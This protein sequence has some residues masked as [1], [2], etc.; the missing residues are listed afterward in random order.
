[1]LAGCEVAF[2]FPEVGE[3]SETRRRRLVRMLGGLAAVALIAVMVLWAFYGSRYS[4]RPAGVVLSPPLADYVAP[5]RARVAKGILLLAKTRILPESY[6][7]G[8]SDVRAMANGMPS[9][10]MGKVYLHGVWFYFPSVLAIKS[11]IGFL[12]L[13]LAAGA[14]CVA[15]KMKRWREV[16]FVLVP[17]GV[18]LW[19]AMTSNLNIGARHILP[20]Y[21][22]LCVFAGASWAWVKRRDGGGADRA[23][24]WLE[25]CW[26]RMLCRRRRHIPT[27]WRTRTRCREVRR[28]RISI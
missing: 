7:Y 17:A 13:V 12:G 24:P 26:R 10:F 1:L 14:G 28:I 3:E 8:L 2:L 22:F 9:Y 11:T 19:T 23:W 15:G 4:A 20:V 5:L 21:V 6:L 27:T 25:Y 16:L 18:Y